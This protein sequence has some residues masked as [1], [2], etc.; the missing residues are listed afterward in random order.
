MGSRDD[1]ALMGW[2]RIDGAILW[3]P[4]LGWV[5]YFV[6]R[7]VERNFEVPVSGSEIGP[8]GS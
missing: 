3:T 7:G 6:R 1:D 5:F 8:Q 2:L 4:P